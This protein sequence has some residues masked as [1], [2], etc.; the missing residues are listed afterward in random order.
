MP[1]RSA[2]DR[3]VWAVDT[4]AVGPSDRLLEIGCG[5]G[6][7]VS[8]V[9]ERLDGGSITAIDRSP[10]MIEMA[11]RRNAEHVA[12]GVASFQ[13][14]SLHEA[15]LDDARFDTVFAIHVGVFVRGRPAR[16]L[17][18]IREHLAP[19]GRLHLVYQPLEPSGVETTVETLSAVLDDH[20]FRVVDVLIGDLPS[21]RTVSVVSQPAPA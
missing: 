10:K 12:A 4:L 21:G 16:E 9:S 17:A 13:V 18:V 2:A 14:A 20:G 3:L 8:L 7:A 15:D 6:V 19:G 5:H 11:Q 1:R